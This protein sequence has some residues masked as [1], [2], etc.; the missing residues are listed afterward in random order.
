MV[1]KAAVAA[2]AV[3]AGLVGVSGWQPRAAA[4]RAMAPDG[5]KLHQVAAHPAPRLAGA[6][7]RRDTV[8][9]RTGGEDLG[10]G[11][12][13][14]N[15]QVLSNML[16]VVFGSEFLG[17]DSNYVRKWV[18][19]MRVAVYGDDRGA[20]TDLIDTHLATLRRLTGLDIKRVAWNDPAVNASILF[21]NR[22]EFRTYARD[23]L[24]RSKPGTNQNL[25]C[26]GVFRGNANREIVGFS[27]MIPLSGSRAE[28]EACIVEEVTQVLGLPNDSYD[29]R[30]S[31]FNDDDQYHE[32]TWQDKLMVR[33]LYD[34][35]IVPGMGRAAFA[36]TA[37]RILDE[38]RPEGGTAVAAAPDSADAPPVQ[39]V[40]A[41]PVP[42][43]IVETPRLTRD[44]GQ[45]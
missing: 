20:Y 26:F 19:P 45:P 13:L 7:D 25:A 29:I 10:V 33:V 23:Y 16:T 36:A 12:W 2:A 30:P 42:S 37:R 44:R 27:A 14:S 8:P 18:G 15:E 17:E 32:L 6:D 40:A 1:W 39:A 43:P 35:R 28:I 4:D 11:V 5:A 24:R 31:V 9:A 3:T 21:L 41:K 38:L 22:P 34:P